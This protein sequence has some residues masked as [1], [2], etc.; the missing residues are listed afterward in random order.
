MGIGIVSAAVNQHAFTECLLYG[1]G[2]VRDLCR[3]YIWERDMDS[4][5]RYM[6]STWV[7]VTAVKG[8]KAK[9]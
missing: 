5:Q 1:T 8:N 2:S 4:K 7:A 6:L 3:V 9:G